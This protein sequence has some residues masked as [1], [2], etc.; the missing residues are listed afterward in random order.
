MTYKQYR[1]S[2]LL[3]YIP[4]L[5]QTFLL[6]FSVSYSQY[7]VYNQDFT[8]Q[9]R[10]NGKGQPYIHPAAV[11]LDRGVEIS[12]NAAE[13]DDLIQFLADLFFPHSQDSSIE[14]DVFPAGQFR[15]KSRTDLQ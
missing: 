10:C 11:S 9:M 8:F 4:H 2:F 5:T 14:I 3:T 1:S 7:F 15:M 12:F 13:I 6:K